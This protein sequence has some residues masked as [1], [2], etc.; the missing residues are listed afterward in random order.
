MYSSA[1]YPAVVAALRADI[2]RPFE[3]FPDVE[4][5]ANLALLPG[6]P[7]NLEALTLGRSGLSLFLE[8]CHDGH[9]LLG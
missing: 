7:R 6:V 2:E 9:S 4:V 1:L 3:L 5:S 8:P